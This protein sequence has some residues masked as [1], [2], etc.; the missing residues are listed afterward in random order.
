MMTP[1]RKTDVGRA[2]PAAPGRPF[3]TDAA[4]LNKPYTPGES[5]AEQKESAES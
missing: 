5:A 4:E 3:A 2:G 1:L